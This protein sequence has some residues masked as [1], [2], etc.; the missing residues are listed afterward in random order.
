MKIILCA[1]CAFASLS[2]ATTVYVINAD[3]VDG[4]DKPA[5][6]IRAAAP[7]ESAPAPRSHSGYITY[8]EQGLPPAAPGCRW[9]RMAVYDSQHHLIG[10]RGDPVGMCP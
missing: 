3:S 5:A 2:V 6:S 7:M 1:V 10:W 9:V 8:S 4:T